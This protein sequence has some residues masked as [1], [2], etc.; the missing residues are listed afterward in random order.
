VPPDI[1]GLAEVV[2]DTMQMAL[3][4]VLEKVAVLQ[5]LVVGR[6]GIAA[7]L[8]K[9]VV[10]L[11]ERTA[12]LETRAPVP[13]PS[14]PAGRDGADGVGY[15]DLA[16]E[17]LDATTVTLKAVRGDVVKTVGTV[18]FPVG[19]FVGDFDAGRGYTPGNI[20]RYK[21]ALWHCHTATA[22][23]PDGVTHDGT[24]RA[25]GPQGKDC[26]MLLL[27]DGKRGHDGKDGGP[28]PVG[29]AGKDWQQ[30]Y[31]DTRRR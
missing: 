4:P 12:V 7:D 24:G 8:S 27:R 17:Q 13:G 31:D 25:A 9:A 29:P 10:D 28:G 22:I 20:V 23:A 2:L 30:V 11:R 5:A 18:T 6:E 3:A 21:S 26:W 15:D 16:L 14:G 1:D 19:T